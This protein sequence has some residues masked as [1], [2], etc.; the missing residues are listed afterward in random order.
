LKGRLSVDYRGESLEI[1]LDKIFDEET[2]QR[3]IYSSIADD[4]ISNL[5]DGI[6]S[7]VMAY[8]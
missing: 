8:G 6:S 1:D 3:E 5:F 7:T 2:T 4:L